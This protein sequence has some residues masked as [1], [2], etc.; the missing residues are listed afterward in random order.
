MWIIFLIT[1]IIYH[2]VKKTT[3]GIIGAARLIVDKNSTN[4][5]IYVRHIIEWE[6]LKSLRDEFIGP[7]FTL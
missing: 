6:Y 2:C 4:L 3:D 1:V 5:L 7:S